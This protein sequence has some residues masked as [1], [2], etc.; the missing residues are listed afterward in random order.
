M[1]V[2]VDVSLCYTISRK[3]EEGRH[4]GE[5]SIGNGLAHGKHVAV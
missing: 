4:D 3:F 1:G 5:R 2:A